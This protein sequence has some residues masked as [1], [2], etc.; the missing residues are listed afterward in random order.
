M[1][2]YFLRIIIILIEHTSTL[3][4]VDARESP[5][6]WRSTTRGRTQK[7]TIRV[8]RVYVC[9]CV[10]AC[11]GHVMKQKIVVKMFE[12]KKKKKGNE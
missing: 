5:F 4:P 1:Y 7:T 8:L 3:S 12:R 11:I 10:C 2:V 6:S 9:V